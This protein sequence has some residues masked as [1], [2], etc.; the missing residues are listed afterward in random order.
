MREPEVVDHPDPARRG[1][2]Y[3]EARI[4]A[5]AIEAT[6]TPPPADVDRG[7]LVIARSMDD[8]ERLLR[9]G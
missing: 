6:P 4:P 9:R 2:I 5:H 1:T 3:E 7:D 8:V